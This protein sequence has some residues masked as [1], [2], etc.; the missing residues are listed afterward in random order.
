M[1]AHTIAP[2]HT[3]TSVH[4]PTARPGWARRTALATTGFL[5]CAL[6]VVFAFNITR[7]LVTGIE[8]DH[9]FHQATGQGLILVAL[10]L[11]AVVPLVVAGWTGRRPSTRAGLQHLAFVGAGIL[12]AALAPGGG[13]PS[14]MAVIAVPGAL[15]WLALPARPR[16]A[17]G[18][19]IDPILMPFALAVTAFLT[20]YALDQVQLQNATTHGYHAQ[21]P[22]LFDMAWLAATVMAL[23]LFAALLPAARSSIGWVAGS[24]LGLG[25]AG[26]A[27]GEGTAW[28]LAVLAFGVVG[29]VLAGLQRRFGE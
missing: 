24:C 15:L 12:C 17:G 10:W 13:A 9:R 6:P 23:A 7:M 3:P 18:V 16:L 8:P 27:F 1:N 2:T 25:L 21:N 20:P 11:G 4:E 14:L 19:R 22:H 29:A 5:T 28:S 26:L